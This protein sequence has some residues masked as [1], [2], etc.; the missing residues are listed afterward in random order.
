MRT[1]LALGVVW[2]CVLLLSIFQF[3]VWLRIVIDVLAM[4][5]FFVLFLDS[6]CQRPHHKGCFR[7]DAN[8]VPKLD[9]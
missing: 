4:I 5:S 7:A 9:Q 3:P 6:V 2:V 8:D 1:W